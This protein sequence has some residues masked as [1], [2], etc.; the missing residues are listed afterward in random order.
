MPLTVRGF[1]LIAAGFFIN[2]LGT[3]LPTPLYPLY[4]E[5]YHLVPVIITVI[6][7]TYAFAVIAGLM[8]FGHQSDKIG[9]R[10]VLLPALAVSGLSAIAFLAAHGLAGLLAGRVLSGL[11]AGIFTGSGTAALVDFAPQERRRA[12]ALAAVVANIGGLAFGTIL[13]GLLAQYVPF[14]LRT[15]YAVDLAL[16]A[17]GFL[18]VLAAPE[19][20]EV[21]SK[22]FRI[23][24]RKLRIPHEMRST[25]T[26]A[27]IAGMSGF[28]VSGVFSAVAPVLLAAQLNVHAP[29]IAGV[30]VF[31]I[32]A[33]SCAGQ[34]VIERLPKGA[35]FAIGSALL[36]AGLAALAAAIASSSL[37]LLFLSSGLSGIGQGIVIGFGLANINERVESAHRGEVTSTYFVLLYL[38]LAVPVVGVG[39]VAMAVGLQIA[40]YI[41]SGVVAVAVLAAVLW[42]R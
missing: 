4:E 2:M 34:I 23:A 39:L 8:L 26:S 20:V 7:A 18:A 1:A 19:T 5:R 10:A 25:F 36:L 38:G 33:A 41:F 28:A 21:T 11:S 17:L 32:F 15:P 22:R 35:A 40:G 12:A 30:L 27:V 9:R 29:A 31:L 6:F 13:A 37:A 3:T 42:P 16:A 24:V 14:P